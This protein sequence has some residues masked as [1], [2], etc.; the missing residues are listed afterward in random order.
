VVEGVV[1]DLPSGEA[2]Q[3]RARLEQVRPAD[4]LIAVAYRLDRGDPAREILRA[5]AETSAD[6]IVMGTHGRGGLSRLLMGR[7]AEAVMRKAECP[8]LTVKAPLPAE[9]VSEQKGAA[10]GQPVG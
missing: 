9:R 2:E 5:A 8:V 6:L 1:I 3:T 10:A 4:P 7:V